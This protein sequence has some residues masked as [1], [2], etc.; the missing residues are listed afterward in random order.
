MEDS[1]GYVDALFE[2]YSKLL[3]LRLDF[4]PGRLKT[5]D[6]NDLVESKYKWLHSDF[7]VL[8]DQIERFLNNMRSNKLFDDKV[9]YIIKLEYAPKRGYH[10]HALLFFNGQN[11]GNET[12]YGTQIANYW[13]GTI[14]KGEGTCFCANRPENKRRYR[15]PAIGVI[16]HRD[17]E[18]RENM[19]R[20]LDY[21][22]KS[23]KYLT[24]KKCVGQ[25][26]L[27]MGRAPRRAE[28]TPRGRP[29]SSCNAGDVNTLADAG[30]PPEAQKVAARV[31]VEFNG[32]SPEG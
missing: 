4:Y 3:V 29:R 5:K 2:K 8:I 1:Q 17:W 10:A 27:R 21:F 23:D 7:D 16:D 19:R 9:G 28:H 13:T 26:L 25:K 20:V 11:V 30:G 15:F 6:I 24:A 14:T 31:Q 18:E 12:F 32:T 22:A